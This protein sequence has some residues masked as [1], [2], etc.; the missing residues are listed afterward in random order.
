M[1][2][3]SLG[4]RA[5]EDVMQIVVHR[6][7][8]DTAPENTF[9]AAAVCSR[10]GADYVEI[11]VRRSMDG[12]HYILHDRTLDR[13]TDG[14][15]PVSRHTSPVIDRLDA[16]GWFSDDYAGARVPRLEEFLDW[17]AGNIGVFLDVKQASLRS[18]VRMIR[19]REMEDSVFFWFDS[20]RR[21]RQFRHLA[22]D[23][24]LKM[25]SNTA[26]EVRSHKRLFDNQIVEY[27]PGPNSRAV[28]EASHELGLRCMATI[29]SPPETPSDELE[30]NYARIVDLGYDIVNLDRPEPFIGYLKSRG[31]R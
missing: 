25:N 22:P 9:E 15:G 16:G 13:T 11:D 31:L 26:D 7:A 21:A 29:F 6:G 12:V 5:D 8:N 4:T 2:A 23:I 20:D 17:A 27:G 3:L 19:D 14:C 10:L 24:P 18:V 28:V 1:G 30:S